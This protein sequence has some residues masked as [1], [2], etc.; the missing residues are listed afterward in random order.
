MVEVKPGELLEHPNVKSRAISSRTIEG[1]GSMEGSTT[2]KVSPNNNL[3]HEH[4][5]PQGDEIV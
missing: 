5:A 3:S 1:M 2:R 4:P